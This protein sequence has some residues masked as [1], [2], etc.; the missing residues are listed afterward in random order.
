MVALPAAE[1]TDIS[2]EAFFTHILMHELMHGLGPS[3]INVDGRQTTVRQELRETYSTIE[4]AKADISGLWALH[5]LIDRGVLDQSLEHSMYT[6]FLASTFRSIRFGINEAHG[7]G[8][9]IQLNTF[10]DAGAVVVDAN[11]RFRVDHSRIRDAVTALTTELMTLQ[12]TGDFDAAERILE[13][14][15]VVRPEVQ[16]LLDELSGIPIDIQPRYVTADALAA[17]AR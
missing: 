13:T 4:E 16:R 14:R 7:R 1:R 8:V 15:G 9:A 10:L 5:Q 6:T 17:A 3:T 12:A 2:F 11:G